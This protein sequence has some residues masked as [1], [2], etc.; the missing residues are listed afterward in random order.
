MTKIVH[1]LYRDVMIN[2]NRH[3]EVKFLFNLPS[4][5][6]LD[7]LEGA[8]AITRYYHAETLEVEENQKDKFSRLAFAHCLKVFN[9]R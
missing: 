5:C 8:C 7:V 6:D 1:A 2:R 9:D 3:Q 4:S